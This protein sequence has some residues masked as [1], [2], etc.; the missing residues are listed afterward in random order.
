MFACIANMQGY[1]LIGCGSIK[2]GENMIRIMKSA[3]PLG[4]LALT[5]L[6]LTSEAASAFPMTFDTDPVL[7]GSPGP[8]VWYV[9]R[10]APASFES[11]FFDGDNRLALG[12]SQA[13][14]ANNR[15]SGFGDLFYDTQGRA[16]DTPGVTSVSIDMYVDGSWAG[17]TERVGGLWG[18]GRDAGNAVSGYPIIEF[19]NGGFQ[20]WDNGVWVSL[21]SA[22][23]VDKWYTLSFALDTASD[24]IRYFIDGVLLATINANS[25]VEFGSVIVQGLNRP[26]P[27]G[28]NRTLYFDNLVAPV[29][30]PGALPLFL[31]GGGAFLF[32]VR[33]RRQTT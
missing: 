5:G 15:P 18:V 4:V 31:S 19:A 24:K 7:S 14:S 1:S 3:A 12:L 8:G 6:I 21:I 23:T 9:D 25:A 22:A 30:L 16:F 11:A 29:P 27:G 17:T 2:G 20:G 10:Y 13:D 33:R 26:N 28:V 32:L